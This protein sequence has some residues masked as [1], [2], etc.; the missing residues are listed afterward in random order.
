MSDVETMHVEPLPSRKPMRGDVWTP[1]LTP[2]TRNVRVLSVNEPDNFYRKAFV[3]IARISTLAQPVRYVEMSSFVRRYALVR[4]EQGSVWG[5]GY[6]VGA[7]GVVRLRA[8]GLAY[9]APNDFGAG[10]P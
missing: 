6:A 9:R 3:R 8:T 4:N 10:C 2:G 5:E 7:D 1:R